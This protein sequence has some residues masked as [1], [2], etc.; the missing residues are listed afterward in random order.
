MKLLASVSVVAITAGF[1]FGGGVAARAETINFFLASSF[2]VGE[3]GKEETS[4][5]T[6]QRFDPALGTLTAVVFSLTSD[7]GISALVAGSF[8]GGEG[9]SAS[10]NVDAAFALYQIPGV[11]VIANTTALASATCT[12]AATSPSVGGVQSCLQSEPPVLGSLDATRTFAVADD[13]SGFIDDGSLHQFS[14]TV[15]AEVTRGTTTC[16]P[17]SP[18]G[19]GYRGGATFEGIVTVDF[20]FRPA[21]DSPVPEPGSLALL[22]AGVLGLASARRRR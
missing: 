1:V 13:L 22:S 6:F 10:V 17:A 7:I 16:S 20:V 18:A 11:G 19:C 4:P 9:G 5:L 14:V 3:P 8:S 12:A 2:D 21:A 15:A